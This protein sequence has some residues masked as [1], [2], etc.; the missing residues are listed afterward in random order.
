MSDALHLGPAFI[1]LDGLTLSVEEKLLILRPSVGG[2]I[3][4]ARNFDS[5]SQLTSLIAS[6][7]EVRAELLIAVDQEGGRVQRFKEGFTRLPPLA[8]FG[9]LYAAKP[10]DA[11]ALA[12]DTGWLLAAE[13]LAVGVD[14]SF[15][16]V[17]DIDRGVSQVI[18]DR[19]FGSQH[20]LVTE[21]AAEMINGMH[22]AGMP[23]T[24]KHFP[25]HGY[26]NADSHIAIPVDDRSY[27]EIEQQD[28]KPFALLAKITEAV[29]PAHV[30]Y[31]HCD[32]RPAG[33][34]TFW[35]Q[36]VLRERL[37]FAGVIF[38]DDLTM[39]GASVAGGFADRAEQAVN[40][41]CDMV[42]VCNHRQ[43]TIEVLDWLENNGH[44]RAE[45]AE[46]MKANPIK[47]NPIKDKRSNI[48][49]NNTLVQLQKSPRWQQVHRQL[50]NL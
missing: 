29:M 17:V 7:R 47:A 28:L 31:P 22:E 11:R 21:L 44:L 38:S 3:L 14:F 16:P 24:L 1:D 4:F 10:D 15:A 41:G 12:R 18:G 13:L 40:A 8:A 30:I 35:Q 2:I 34:S 25:G 45:K 49:R 20:H 5:V 43:G 32:D 23:A 26:V 42:L 27:E 46:R 48:K 39:E 36:T 19:S 9:K 50:L 33:F 6:I 37:G